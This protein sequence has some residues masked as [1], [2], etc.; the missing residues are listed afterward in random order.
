MRYDKKN[1]INSLRLI[2]IFSYI[3]FTVIGSVVFAEVVKIDS[4]FDGKMDQWRHNTVDGKISKI[5]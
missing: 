1:I 4:N 2:L 3:L 5:Q